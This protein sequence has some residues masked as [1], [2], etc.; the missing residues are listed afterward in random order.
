MSTQLKF[1]IIEDQPAD[2]RLIVR[3]LEKCGLAARCHCVADIKELDAAIAQGGWDAVLSDYS[4][5]TL[6]FQHTLRV[7][8]TRQPDVPVILVSGSVGEER[9]V[10]LL[11]QGVW[12]FVLKDNLTRLVPAIERG[13]RDAAGRR[14]RKRD[15]AALRASEARYRILFDRA[16]D[17]IFL[18]SAD[19]KLVAVNESLARMHGYSVAE[20]SQINL[21]DLDTP[22]TH[23]RASERIARL[24]AGE[25]LTFEVEHYH[26]DGH[27]FPLEVSASLIATGEQSLIQCFHRDISERVRTAAALERQ[28]ED[29]RVRNDALTR[30]NAVAVGR[31]LRM[32]ELKREVNDLCGKLGEPPRHKIVA[33]PP[34]S[35]ATREG[36][37]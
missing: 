1:L 32:I 30:F 11:K 22:E 36:P 6:D 13:L 3:H 37:S 12:D 24:L 29:L 21:K 34:A 18:L 9:A 16:N 5:P 10:E 25:N 23:Q 28:A 20:M 8:Q 31:E 35:S 19:G 14:E 7:L 26:K 4:V 17:G 15:A 33:A 2:F 27:V